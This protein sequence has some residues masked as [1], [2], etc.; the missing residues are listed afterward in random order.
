MDL[1]WCTRKDRITNF[2]NLGWDFDLAQ[3]PCKKSE[4]DRWHNGMCPE[5]RISPGRERFHSL[6]KTFIIRVLSA[7]STWS[8]MIQFGNIGK[9]NQSLLLS[10]QQ[11]SNQSGNIILQSGQ[12]CQGIARHL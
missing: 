7:L 6:L 8:G 12:Y 10:E 9:F 1:F 2:E 5:I 3:L 4:C 11:Y